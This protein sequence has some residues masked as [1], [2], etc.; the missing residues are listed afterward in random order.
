[1]R[2]W[3]RALTVAMLAG[4][5]T[6][7][8]AGAATATPAPAGPA[9]AAA[10]S[11]PRAAGPTAPVN[12]CYTQVCLYQLAVPGGQSLEAWSLLD[13]GPTPYYYSIF[14]QTTG[15]RIA[16]CGVGTSCTSAP[17]YLPYNVCHQYVAYIGGSGFVAPP[18]PVQRQSDQVWFCGPHLG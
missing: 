13:V 9:A 16:V 10:V 4:A 3:I 1:M 7:L 18:A 8:A 11:A 2:T 15:S 12:R 14:D 5:A 6:L 17:I